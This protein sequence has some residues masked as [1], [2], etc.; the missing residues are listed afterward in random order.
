VK[1]RALAA[2]ASVLAVACNPLSGTGTLQA[3]WTT[4][5]GDSAAVIMPVTGRWCVGPGR[6]DIRAAVG[7]TGLGLSVFASDSSA[8]DGS[9]PVN[10]PDAQLTIRPGS[11][12]AL[13]WM[14]KITVEGWWGDS[15]SVMLSGGALR[16]LSGSGKV[17]LVS[18]LGPDSL[19]TL[20]FSFRGVR[21]RNDTLCDVPVLPVAMPVDSAATLPPSGVH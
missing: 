6:L 20:D 4:P 1:G 13:R 14:S 10:Q 17:W 11:L 16:G 2:A 18:G 7:D 12:V 5:A 15:G 19:T 21:V 8:L 3:K 9:Y